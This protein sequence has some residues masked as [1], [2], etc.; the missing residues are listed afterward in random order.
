MDAS[1]DV[2]PA[3]RSILNAA[4]DR[5]G[6]DERLS[7]EARSLPAAFEAATADD[8]VPVI[9]EVK[10]TSPTT[11]G[12]RTEDPVALA[13]E[14]VAGGAAALSV[15]TEPEH[16]GGSREALTRVRDAVNVPVLRKDF[17]LKEAHL[18]AVTADV[19]LLIARFLDDVSGMLTAA[20]K[21]GFQ[22]LVEVHTREEL[23]RALAAGADIIGINNRDLARLEVDLGTFER[24]APAAP[25]DVT[26]IAESGIESVDDV[27]RM[28]AAGAD[29]LLIGTAIM[30]GD[31]RTNTETLTRSESA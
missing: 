8:R 5:P 23:D 11:D 28:R 31:V 4:A 25:D 30:D 18:D 15:L 3:V 22:T 1:E 17:L 27:R 6:G 19:V 14:M 12:E 24:V 7:V 29:A 10:P 26:L 2:A 16:F 9:A 20:R 13:R 21:R